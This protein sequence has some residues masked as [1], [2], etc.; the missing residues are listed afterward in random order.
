MGSCASE[1]SLGLLKGKGS[2]APTPGSE[3]GLAEVGGVCSKH[4]S[5]GMAG[6]PLMSKEEA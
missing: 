6:W 4:L 3:K 1:P 2:L 5:L